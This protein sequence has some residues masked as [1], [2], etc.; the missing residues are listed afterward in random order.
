MGRGGKQSTIPLE[1]LQAR[2]IFSSPQ[3]EVQG[4]AVQPVGC[5]F[6]PAHRSGAARKDQEGGLKNIFDVLLIAEHASTN[7]GDESGVS[8]HKFCKGFFVAIASK[9]RQKFTIRANGQLAAARDSTD[10]AYQDLQLGCHARNSLSSLAV[11]TQ[12]KGLSNPAPARIHRL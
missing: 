5:G 11:L 8:S 1:F 7:P 9:F 12:Y 2:R 10:M 6:M 3:C 4:H